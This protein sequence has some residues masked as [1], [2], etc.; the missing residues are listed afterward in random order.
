MIYIYICHYLCGA[1]GLVH[2]LCNYDMKWHDVPRIL[3]L[4]LT[5][6]AKQQ[7]STSR[8]GANNYI[9]H[10]KLAWK[11]E[12]LKITTTSISFWP[13]ALTKCNS[14]G[15]WSFWCYVWL[16]LETLGPSSI[17][18]GPGVSW[19]PTMPDCWFRGLM[20]FCLDWLQVVSLG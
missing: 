5:I 2:R 18:Y 3:F 12:D 6:Y 7:S 9:N 1:K 11:S 13:Q 20:P 15:R 16:S 14:T 8:D 10:L 17:P 19:Y 4:W